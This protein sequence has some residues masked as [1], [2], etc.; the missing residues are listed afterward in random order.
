[1]SKN[2][3]RA[4]H[5]LDPKGAVVEIPLAWLLTPLGDA[6]ELVDDE[7]T[8]EECIDCDQRSEQAPEVVFED[9]DDEVEPPL[10]E[11]PNDD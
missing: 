4:R 5:I 7:T 3:V 10:D 11:D 6:Y 1:M 2:F 8:D 9:D